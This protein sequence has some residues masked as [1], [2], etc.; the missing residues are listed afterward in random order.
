MGS[1]WRPFSFGVGLISSAALIALLLL[2]RRPLAAAWLADLGAV[3][4]ARIELADFPTG[5]WDDGR[6]VDRLAP[7]AAL[8]RQALQF[9]PQNRTANYRLGLILMLQ[10]DFESA[11]VYLERAYAADRDHRGIV[12]VLGYS[13]AWAG[14]LD[15]ATQLL[16]RIP[17]AEHEMRV[18][19]DWWGD[20]GR[21][22]L[23]DRAAQMVAHLKSI[24]AGTEGNGPAVEARG[25]P[26][27]R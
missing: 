7:S 14:N 23:A 8:L 13:H 21:A 10:R 9:D 15:E 19:V 16:A 4:M 26:N 20:Q 27:L 11:L 5:K 18:Y 12:K 3:E 22:D 1:S 24:N 2:F 17:E 25:N 6:D